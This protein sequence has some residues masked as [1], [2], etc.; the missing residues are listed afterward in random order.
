MPYLSFIINMGSIII[1][2]SDCTKPLTP[3]A[4]LTNQGNEWVFGHKAA[5]HH[6]SVGLQLH[7]GKD[8]PPST[9]D[10]LLTLSWI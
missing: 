1:S 4:F 6:V 9:A 8:G 7:E 2:A 10:Q 3:K 5:L